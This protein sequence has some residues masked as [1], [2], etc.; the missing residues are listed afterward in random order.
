MAGI[1]WVEGH[2]SELGKPLRRPLQKHGREVSGL[3]SSG[4]EED[5][6]KFMGVRGRKWNP[7]YSVMGRCRR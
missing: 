1:W 4:G 3:D 6:G 2:W 7:Q 5:G